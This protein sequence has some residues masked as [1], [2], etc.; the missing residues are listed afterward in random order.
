MINCTNISYVPEIYEHK[1]KSSKYRLLRK[2]VALVFQTSPFRKQR[3]RTP[4]C[5]PSTL[6]NTQT[7]FCLERYFHS[8]KLPVV[9]DDGC[10]PSLKIQ[11]NNYYQTQLQIFLLNAISV[12]VNTMTC[13]STIVRS[14]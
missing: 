3:N 5:K 14:E 13:R 1:Y 2:N 11:A 6:A 7:I 10:V 4:H 9:C 8:L 12:D